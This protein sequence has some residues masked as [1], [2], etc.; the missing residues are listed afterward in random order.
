MTSA[1]DQRSGLGQFGALALE[2]LLGTPEGAAQGRALFQRLR[3]RQQQHVRLSEGADLKAARRHHQL[4][5]CHRMACL[6]LGRAQI[7]GWVET[8]RV[9]AEASSKG[10][11]E[12]AVDT[13]EAL[14]DVLEV[15]HFARVRGWERECEQILE[16]L[17]TAYPDRA[18][19]LLGLALLRFDQARYAQART[20]LEQ[21]RRQV[22]GY[23]LVE[24]WL[25]M[26]ALAENRLPVAADIFL[27]VAQQ[28]AEGP[29]HALARA[30]LQLPELAPFLP[31]RPAAPSASRP[32]QGG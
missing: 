25:G 1:V 18:C 20:C 32:L 11:V 29:A 7:A 10:A 23:A 14:Q 16:R 2:E 5:D 19:A 27:R 3:A 6:V 22:P 17:A 21:A 8:Q 30:M 15:A 24:A 12:F 9:A 4:A 28:S 13:D 31:R 26:V